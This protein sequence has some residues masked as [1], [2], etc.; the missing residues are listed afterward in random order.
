MLIAS[1][2]NNGGPGN[3]AKFIHVRTMN[4][5]NSV[6]RVTGDKQSHCFASQGG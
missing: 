5:C 2:P 4:I 1:F 3:E 6:Q